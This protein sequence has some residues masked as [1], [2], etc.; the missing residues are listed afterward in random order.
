MV[1]TVATAATQTADAEPLFAGPETP[2]PP[3]PTPIGSLVAPPVT[4][5]K[6][7]H[8]ES[9]VK[10]EDEYEKLNSAYQVAWNK[11]ME[12]GPLTSASYESAAALLISWDEPFDD[13]HVKKE[14]R[15]ISNAHHSSL[16]YR[17]ST[18]SEPSSPRHST[19]RFAKFILT[20][21][22]EL[23]HRSRLIPMLRNSWKKKTMP[24]GF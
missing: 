17:R 21:V 16:T 1:D 20:A 11:V 18:A 7:H 10:Y 9:I 12:K 6:Q 19:T 15:V 22:T 24:E 5:A 13:L 23:H 8:D 3:S 4:I 2:D 14:V